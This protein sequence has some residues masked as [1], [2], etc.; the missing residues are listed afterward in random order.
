MTGEG[1]ARSNVIAGMDEH[2]NILVVE[3]DR[4]YAEFVVDTLRAAGHEVTIAANG[5]EAREHVKTLHV[6]AVI[7]DLGLP[8][9]NGYDLARAL[10]A[11]LLARSAIIILLTADLYPERDRADAVGIDMVLSKPVEPQLVL[12]MVDLIHGRRKRRL[13]RDR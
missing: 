7:L 3:D 5:A 12:G 6:D 11:G 4:V 13:D 1:R 9:E 8:D 2:L 10:R